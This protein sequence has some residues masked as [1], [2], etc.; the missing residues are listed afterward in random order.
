MESE[1]QNVE[2]KVGQV[3]QPSSLNTEPAGGIVPSKPLSTD[4]AE[5]QESV[6]QIKQFLLSTLPNLISENQ[7]LLSLSGLILIGVIFTYLT[8][9]LLDAINHIP[10]VAPL[11][12]LVGL[13]YSLWFA[14]RYLRFA[15]TRKELAAEFESLKQDI[16]GENS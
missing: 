9:A 4:Q 5:L 2:T 15:S 11:L 3:E 7:Q 13:G 14:W 1:F 8:V 10:V 12:E 6:T 16:L